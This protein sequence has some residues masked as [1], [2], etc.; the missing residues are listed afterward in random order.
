MKRFDHE[1]MSRK[2][3]A[4][5]AAWAE[6][7]ARLM[8]EELTDDDGYPTDAALELIEKWHWLDTT[9][10]LEFIKD[11]WHLRSWGWAEVDANDL[12]EKDDDYDKDGGKLYFISTAGWSGNESIIHALKSNSMAWGLTW[13]Q[14]RR[15]GHYIFKQHELKDDL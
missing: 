2:L 4:D 12:D 9:G 8:Q 6:L 14:S 3:E 7:K 15:G 13:V 5:K 1:E 11:I 10:L